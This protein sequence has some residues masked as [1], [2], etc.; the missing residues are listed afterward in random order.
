MHSLSRP[1]AALGFLL[2]TA[3]MAA[4]NSGPSAN[5]EFTFAA[6]A[7]AK[8]LQFD[9]RIQ[10]NNNQTRG[11]IA[12]TGDESFG[13]QDVDGGGDSNPGGAHASLKLSADVQCLRIEGNRAVMAGVVTSSSVPGYIGVRTLLVVEDGGEG[14]NAAAD[15]FTWGMYRGTTLTW[16]ATD[17][18]LVFDPGVGLTWWATDA[19]R[20]DDVG[21]PSHPANTGVDCQSFALEAY[22]LVELPHGAGNIQV[23][24]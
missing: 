3:T 18:E 21:R 5:G 9:A 15:K 1:L 12:L 10:N 4:Q 24:P 14:K 2:V 6:G 19:E 13:D 17:A 22:D 23:K 8:S 16:V 7:S 20:L 11:Q